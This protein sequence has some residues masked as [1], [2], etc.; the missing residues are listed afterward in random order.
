MEVGEE[1]GKTHIKA[2]PEGLA[3]LSGFL[4]PIS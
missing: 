4:F 3:Y 2:F 1:S